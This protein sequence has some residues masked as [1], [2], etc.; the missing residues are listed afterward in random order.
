[1]VPVDDLRTALGKRVRTLRENRGM[2][3]ER[4]AE[5]AE[6]HWTYISGIERG[7]R[8]PGLNTLARLAHALGIPVSQLLSRLEADAKRS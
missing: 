1:L 4:L 5:A 3:Q 6:L 7:R 2:S 8:N